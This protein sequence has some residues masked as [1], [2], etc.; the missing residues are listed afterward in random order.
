M[1][2]CAKCACIYWRRSRRRIHGIC[3]YVPSVCAFIVC[4]RTWSYANICMRVS[5][6]FVPCPPAVIYFTRDT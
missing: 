3:V 4:I 5:M 6:Y 2:V 1:C